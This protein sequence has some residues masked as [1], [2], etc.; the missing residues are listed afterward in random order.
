MKN[1]VLFLRDRV[2]LLTSVILIFSVKIWAQTGQKPTVSVADSGTWVY[3]LVCA[4]TLAAGGGLLWWLRK[5]QGAPANTKGKQQTRN[6]RIS[7]DSGSVDVKKEMEW[8]RKHQK[9]VGGKDFR[10]YPKNSSQANGLD[11]TLS[12]ELS[13]EGEQVEI[14]SMERE[15]LRQKMLKIQFSQ[16]PI[17][18]ITELKP[19]KAYDPLS[20]SDNEDLLSAIDQA[21]DEF[22][23]DEEVRELSVKILA[24]FKTRNSIEALSQIAHYD[25]SS[26]LRSKAVGVLADFDHESVFE[27]ILLACADPSREIRATAAR[28][29]F[30]LSFDRADAW[31]RIAESKDEFRICQAA[32]AATEAD[33]VKRSFERL[34][35]DDPKVAYEAFAFT[36]LMIKAGE[37][38]QLFEMIETH[39]DNNV[40]LALLH[41][42]SVIR[43]EATLSGLYNLLEQDTL[44]PEL[45]GKVDETIKS[46][47]MVAA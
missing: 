37:T 14:I 22:E 38:K 7:P 13:S 1:E 45:K 41:V 40:K 36:A 44:S 8:Y 34:I 20:I 23:E 16:L 2:S 5:K 15:A 30:R 11:R 43:D 46:F 35:F 4:A 28:G 26:N 12:G 19:A 27:T 21:N 31:T 6:G 42:L 9:T 25:I 29:I 3:I 17:T 47:E 39:R 18:T 24:A 10:R 33:L 32:R